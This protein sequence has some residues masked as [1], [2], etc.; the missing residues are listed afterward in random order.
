[1]ARPLRIEFVGAVYH[2]TARGNAREDIYQ[3]DTGS[4]AVLDVVAEYGQS[5]RLVLSRLL[6]NGQS[7][8]F[9]D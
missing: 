9:T 4:A 1:M 2:V 5:L 8:S 6:P 7:L 3:D